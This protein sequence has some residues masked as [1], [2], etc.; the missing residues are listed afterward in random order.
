MSLDRQDRI[1]RY[2]RGEMPEGEM[3]AFERGLEKDDF[4]SHQYEETLLIAESI[5]D[6]AADRELMEAFRMT[7][8][9]EMKAFMKEKR[10]GRRF[11]NRRLG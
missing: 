8:E 6:V 1:D 5:R 2:I 3:Q 11:L 10:S 9:E 4:L 7:S